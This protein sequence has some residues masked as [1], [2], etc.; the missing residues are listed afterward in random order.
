MLIDKKKSLQGPDPDLVTEKKLKVGL[1][2]ERTASVVE[3]VN[4]WSEK[5]VQIFHHTA[6]NSDCC[7]RLIFLKTIITKK[8]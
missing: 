5:A 4:W 2:A 7:S 6:Q 1:M 8:Y 3:L